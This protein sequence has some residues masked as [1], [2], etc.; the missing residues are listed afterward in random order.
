MFVELGKALVHKKES[1]SSKTDLLIE[2][3]GFDTNIKLDEKITSYISKG[4][5]NEPITFDQLAKNSC[6]DLET[7]IKALGILKADVDNMGRFLK[8][9]DVTNNFNNFEIFSKTLDAFFAIHLPRV[10]AK[11]F[12]DAYTVFAG[13]DDLFLVG[14]WDTIVLLARF[15]ESEFKRFIKNKD[16]SISVAVVIAKSSTPIGYLSEYVENQLEKAKSMDGKDS[17]AF[18]G[19]CSKW[20]S[21]KEVHESLGSVLVELAKDINTAFLYRL[22][23]FCDMSQNSRVDIED[24][25]W[26]SRFRYSLARNNTNL[27]KESIELIAKIIENRPE[28]T[29]MVLSEFIYK[30]RER[31]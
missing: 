19:E 30:R 28:Q 18:A 6:N 11:D 22:L 29:R 21:Y 5:N 17:I 7:G 14:S 13:G 15:V 24:T 26:R 1:L 16:L 8:N 2:L 4:I 27:S 25:M 9:S 10:M 3:D 31:A 23:T 12:P 20:E